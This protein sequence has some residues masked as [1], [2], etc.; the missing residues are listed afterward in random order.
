MFFEMQK[1][2]LDLRG[3]YFQWKCPGGA[4]TG[5]NRFQ[6]T[7]PQLRSGIGFKEKNQAQEMRVNES[8]PGNFLNKLYTTVDSPPACSQSRA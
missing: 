7:R 1:S 5:V 4:V 2:P 3:P 6:N 8:A